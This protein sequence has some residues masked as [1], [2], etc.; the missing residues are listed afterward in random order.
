MANNWLNGGIAKSAFAL[1]SIRFA[2]ALCE[3]YEI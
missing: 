3:K 2:R 1:L